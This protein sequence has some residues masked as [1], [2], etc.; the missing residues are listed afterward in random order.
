MSELNLAI[1]KTMSDTGGLGNNSLT[2]L[3][4]IQGNHL[5]WSLF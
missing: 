3:E 4:K 5:R 1:A 2:Y